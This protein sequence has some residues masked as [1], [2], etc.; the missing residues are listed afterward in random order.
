MVKAQHTGKE[1]AKKVLEEQRKIYLSSDEHKL[2]KYF[3]NLV[4]FVRE[5]SP[6]GENFISKFHSRT[7]ILQQA[8]ATFKISEKLLS[9]LMAR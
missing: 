9:L 3:E 2:F 4:G 5:S 7:N 8:D 6:D 1:S